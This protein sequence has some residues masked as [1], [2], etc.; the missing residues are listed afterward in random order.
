MTKTKITTKE[1]KIP[2]YE[3]DAFMA[4][5]A[6]PEDASDTKKYPALV[7]IQEIFGVNQ[8]MRNKCEE[9]AAMGYITI[10]PDLFWRIQPNIQ[11]VDNKE[12]ELKRAFELFGQFSTELGI[13]DLKTTVGYARHMPE[14]NKKVGAIGYCLGG[15]L[16]YRL[17]AACE[18]DAA[19]SYYG[20]NIH[21]HLDEIPLI[22][23]PLMLHIAGEDEFVN[24]DA[25]AK[26]LAAVDPIE[27][28]TAYRYDGVNHAFARGQGTHYDKPSADI[29]N[30]RSQ[31]FL[32]DHLSS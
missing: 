7:M 14:V 1:I 17:A 25:Q 4:Y 18:L 15:H 22:K 2:A 30:E 23:E 12:E 20:V 16:S 21:E 13:E 10:C 29:A 9:Y 26:I 19:V 8:E 11:L 31:T 27:N 28:I 3:G 32:K 6:M 24:K 5:I